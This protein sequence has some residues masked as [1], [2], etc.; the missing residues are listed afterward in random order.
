MKKLFRWFGGYVHISLTGRQ[1]NRFLNLCSRNGIPIWNI[2]QDIGRYIRVHLRLKDFFYLKPFLK[3]TKTHMRILGKHGYPFWCHRHPRLKWFPAFVLGFVSLI[4]YSHT[5]IWQIQVRG[6]NEVSEQELLQFLAAQEIEVGRKLS[7]VD[8]AQLE[9][10]IRQNYSQL[11][12]VSVYVDKTNLCIEVRESLYG[13]HKELLKEDIR[14]DLVADKDAYIYSMITRT[15]KAVVTKDMYVHKGDL[16]VEGTCDIVN[17]NGEVIDV[18]QKKAEA[19]IIG[20]VE[21]PIIDTLTDMELVSLQITG[22]Y[23]E[24]MLNSI[25]FTKI[26]RFLENLEE[27]GVIILNK[28]VMIE[29]SENCFIFHGTIKVREEIGINIP[30]E[31][32]TENEFE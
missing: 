16:L 18:L 24:E 26:N 11:G 28:S 12:W 9:Y 32:V 27:N 21:Y 13:E 22:L 10:S 20:D 23:S 3:K 25:A 15:G 7:E 14:Y 17:D 8:C 5:F 30:V 31:E 19:L 1:V 4:I 6:N 2:S 29:K